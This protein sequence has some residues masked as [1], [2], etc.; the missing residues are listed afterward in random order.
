MSWII[1]YRLNKHFTEFLCS[2]F[3]GQK[4]RKKLSETVAFAR[5]QEIPFLWGKNC[6]NFIATS[7]VKKVL[8]S[9]SVSVKFCLLFLGQQKLQ[10]EFLQPQQKWYPIKFGFS[11]TSKKHFFLLNCFFF[12]PDAW[13]HSSYQLENKRQKC[14]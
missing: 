4:L 1:W 13:E 8:A 14:K 10:N 2:N 7:L 12:P 5:R 11:D 9:I 3:Q 6:T